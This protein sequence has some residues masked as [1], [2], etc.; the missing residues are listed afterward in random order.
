MIH[1]S[2]KQMYW[3]L[4]LGFLVTY[5][6]TRLANI[7]AFPIFT[8][9]AI[10]LRWAQI[11]GNDADW[12]FISLTDG[13]QPLFVWLAMIFQKVVDDPLLAGR[14]VSVF[15]G[16]SSM[17]GLFFLTNEIFRGKSKV[18]LSARKIGIVA[19]FLYLLY[20][21]ALVYD[22]LALYDSLVATLLFGH[23]IWKCSW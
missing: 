19:A 14:L 13:K 2:K 23:Y 17:V 1:L 20:P 9:E 22:R 7:T 12:L 4:G 10:Y 5:L 16:L 15:A 3:F 8:D 18:S 6:F 11:A 21:F